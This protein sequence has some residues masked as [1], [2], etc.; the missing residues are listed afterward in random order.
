[1]TDNPK[2][3]HCGK[4]NDG[5]TMLGNVLHVPHDGDVSL[6]AYCGGCGVFEHGGIRTPTDDEQRDFDADPRL[7]RAR[8]VL[9]IISMR[10]AI[11]WV[12]KH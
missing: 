8:A 4:D 5:H 11:E 1:M 9:A 12:T 10:N 3:P 7:R 6:C 2:C